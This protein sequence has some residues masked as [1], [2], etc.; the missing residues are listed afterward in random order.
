MQLLKLHAK[1][2]TIKRLWHWLT[3]AILLASA[4]D[5]R[6]RRGCQCASNCL[7]QIVALNRTKGNV[8]QLTNKFCFDMLIQR[9][10]KR[11]A[12]PSP[13]MELAATVQPAPSAYD[14][15]NDPRYLNWRNL[16]LEITNEW[17]KLA[18]QLASSTAASH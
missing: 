7:A 17:G 18:D 3:A 10:S 15:Q 16:I 1:A 2:L 14:W 9:L 11:Y 8:F 12:S 4:A 5:T 6:I 13:S